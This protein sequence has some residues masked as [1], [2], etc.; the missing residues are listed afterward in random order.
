MKTFYFGKIAKIAALSA[1]ILLGVGSNNALADSFTITFL[2][3]GVQ[4]PMGITTNYETFNEPSFSGTTTFNGSPITG[5]YSGPYSIFAANQ[6]GGAGGTGNY[7]ATPGSGSYTLTLSQSVDYFGLW[8]SALDQGNELSFY[9]GS[10]LVFNFSPTN[11]ATLVGA[12]PNGANPF[13]GNPNP[14]FLGFNSGQQYAYLNFL[15]T[16]GTFNKIVFDENPA[17]GRFESDNQAVGNFSSIPGT[18]I[19]QTPEPPSLLLFGTGILGLAG[20]VFRHSLSKN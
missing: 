14:P 12:C 19:P 8:F 2:A 20:A 1:A 10:T 16:T 5:T 17:V 11:F 4:T 6:F 15:D 7:I 3:A 18:P 9:N 13:C